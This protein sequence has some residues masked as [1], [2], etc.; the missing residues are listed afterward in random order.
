MC[1]LGFQFGGIEGFWRTGLSETRSI[2]PT[3]FHCSS[4]SVICY[5]PHQG[6]R[7]WVVYQ[8]LGHL[9]F[10]AEVSPIWGFRV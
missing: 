3:E 5:G 6:C 4:P 8:V 9:E 7:I 2:D 10:E 1:G